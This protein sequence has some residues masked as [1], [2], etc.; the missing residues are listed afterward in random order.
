VINLE[1][2][3]KRCVYFEINRS[4]FVKHKLLFSL[5]LTLTCLQ[6]KGVLK[7]E[8]YSFLVTGLSG[9]SLKELENPGGE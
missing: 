6:D 1:E 7:E 2:S 3:L 4:I 9:K 5:L 8:L